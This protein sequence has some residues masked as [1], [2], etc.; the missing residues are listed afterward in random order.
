ML[1]LMSCIPILSFG[2]CVLGAGSLL[3]P[4]VLVV[5]GL[6]D[7]GESCG[8]LGNSSCCSSHG[9]CPEGGV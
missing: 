5:S 3:Y 4:L 1:T 8:G 6:K 9:Q 2:L 7:V